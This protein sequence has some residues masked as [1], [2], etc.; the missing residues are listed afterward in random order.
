MT[1]VSSALPVAAS[2]RTFSEPLFSDEDRDR[3]LGRSQSASAR[4]TSLN[5]DEPK[6]AD[7]GFWINAD[8]R[9]EDFEVLRSEGDTEWLGQ[10][11]RHITSRRYAP[12]S[13]A[14]D[15]APGFYM[16]ERYSAVARFADQVTG[17][18]LRRREPVMRIERLDITPENYNRPYIE[19]KR[20][21]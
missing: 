17:S 7:I 11:E 1:A 5:M 18:R 9:V 19:G 10:V 3:E 8:G 14:E 16:I 15:A 21:G 20:E 4:L 13:T 12:L 2:T 6:W